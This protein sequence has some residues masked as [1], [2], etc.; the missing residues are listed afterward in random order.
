MQALVLHFPMH[1]LSPGLLAHQT[2]ATAAV[3]HLKRRQIGGVIVEGGKAP[4]WQQLEHAAFGI[5]AHRM[6]CALKLDPAGAM[7]AGRLA[8]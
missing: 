4:G 3:N 6:E 7:A 5:T 8:D 1:M 2:P